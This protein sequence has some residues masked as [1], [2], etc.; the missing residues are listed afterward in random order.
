MKNKIIISFVALVVVLGIIWETTQDNKSQETNESVK[1]G[2]L[3]PM[4]G[5]AAYFGETVANG[6]RLAYSEDLNGG[7][8][9]MIFDD[10]KCKPA[11][12]VSIVQKMINID[13]V[14]VIIGGSCSSVTLAIAPIIEEAGVILISPLAASPKVTEAGDFVFRLSASSKI[15]SSGAARFVKDLGH[16]RVGL[17]F[18]D[19]EYP[20]GWK[21]AFVKEF[22]NQSGN[23]VFI[24]KV[25]MASTD[26]RTQLLKM[27]SKDLDIL[28]F[29]VITHPS[30]HALLQQ[31]ADI[32]ID[33]PI[34]GN[35]VFAYNTVVEQN[36]DLNNAMLVV[37]YKYNSNSGDMRKFLSAYREKYDVTLA[38]EIIGSLGYDTYNVL[39]KALDGCFTR[40]HVQDRLSV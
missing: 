14:D 19:N 33:L 38:D 31:T 28:V 12:G 25:G 36:S 18:E 5:P 16:K 21:D 2:F 17:I 27:K 20:V 22:K 26:V 11:E 30:A 3:S 32:G 8:I 40:Y 6:V 29:A 39:N 24:E 34:F 4:T 23:E 7:R 10:S 13:K 1:V 15:M 37:N 9:K 35:E